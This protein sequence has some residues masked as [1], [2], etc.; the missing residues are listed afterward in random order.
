MQGAEGVQTSN[1]DIERSETVSKSI[2]WVDSGIEPSGGYLAREQ[3]LVCPC[4]KNLVI[5]PAVW[6]YAQKHQ[7]GRVS[8][9]GRQLQVWWRVG[10]RYLRGK[11]PGKQQKA[12]EPREL[13]TLQ[14]LTA[15]ISSG[16]CC[17]RLTHT[18][19]V[20][21]DFTYALPFMWCAVPI[22]CLISIY[23][24]LKTVLGPFS[25]TGSLSFW[26]IAPGCSHVTMN[27]PLW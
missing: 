2:Q 7:D 8:N 16:M 11:I 24:D 20:P 21:W 9:G 26:P 18:M 3:W 17:Q 14:T 1:V 5:L 12:W 6:G 23:S 25:L 27:T 15:K 4:P 13:W 22:A 10:Q 19:T